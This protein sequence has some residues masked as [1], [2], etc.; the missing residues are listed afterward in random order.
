[1]NMRPFFTGYIRMF[2]LSPEKYTDRLMDYYEETLGHPVSD[3]DPASFVS[4]LEVR[5]LIIHCEDDKIVGSGASYDLH[6][7]IDDSKIVITRGLGH[8]RILSDDG[9]AREISD[10]MASLD[11][12]S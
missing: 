12:S 7:A 5:A 10:F 11:T 2:D 8:S 9:V 3:F 6:D 1:M 4:D